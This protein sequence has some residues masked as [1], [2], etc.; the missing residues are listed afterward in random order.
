MQGAA[1]PDFRRAF[2]SLPLRHV[3]NELQ[4]ITR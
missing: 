3:I 2:S 1:E 4:R